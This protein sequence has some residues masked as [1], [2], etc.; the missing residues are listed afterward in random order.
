MIFELRASKIHGVGVFALSKIKKGSV[1]PLFEKGD[2]RFLQMNQIKDSGIPR[3]ILYKY[4]IKFP[5]G[6][7]TPKSFNRMSV[8][9]YLN[10]S[11]KPN[12]CNDAKYNF[13]AISDIKKD[14]EI[15]IDYDQL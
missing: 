1:L 6:Y 9:W 11:E 5:D 10:H 15:V 12:A 13:T 14:E 4:S 7:S 2:S 3:K 8:G